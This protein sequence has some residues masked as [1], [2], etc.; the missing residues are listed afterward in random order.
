MGCT[1]N[2]LL[3]A[4]MVSGAL[5][6]ASHVDAADVPSASAPFLQWVR[7]AAGPLELGV[8]TKA[9]F[10]AAKE[11][12]RTI[13]TTTYRLFPGR[14]GS[15]QRRFPVI[16]GKVRAIVLVF[17]H[18]ERGAV[19]LEALRKA[20]GVPPTIET[21]RKGRTMGTTAN[22]IQPEDLY[23]H[24]H[25]CPLP[26]MPGTSLRVVS[27]IDTGQIDEIHIGVATDEVCRKVVERREREVR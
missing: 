17:D 12:D 6:G 7:D 10:D 18:D 21:H 9:D 26:G 20:I 19:P 27:M 1:F 25:W 4:L 14:T 24:H 13:T 2:R 22:P 5:L 16:E 11:Q 15:V 23:N 8:S 3:V